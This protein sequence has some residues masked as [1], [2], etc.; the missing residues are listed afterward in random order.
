MESGI[1]TR[2]DRAQA[3]QQTVG[4]DSAGDAKPSVIC[5]SRFG[6]RLHVV[7][8]H[9]VH[10]RER[11]YRPSDPTGCELGGADLP[12]LRT[13]AEISVAPSD[14]LQLVF[15]EHAT[16]LWVHTIDGG[17]LSPRR[18]TTCSSRD[19]VFTACGDPGQ[20]TEIVIGCGA[21]EGQKGG[22]APLV[23]PLFR[24]EFDWH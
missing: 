13:I 4:H 17:L 8:L 11:P 3:V 23:H 5:L 19:E 12:S 14:L 20:T 24:T 15:Q 16:R 9:P 10:L 1:I 2:T 18:T 22:R 6:L 7:K 21:M